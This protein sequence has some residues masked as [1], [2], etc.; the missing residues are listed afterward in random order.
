MGDRADTTQLLRLWH[1]GDRKAL[2]ALIGRELPWVRAQAR[3]RLGPLLKARAETE[4]Y[5]QEALLEVLRYAPRFFVADGDRFRALLLRI[6]ENVI[7]DEHDR[8]SA[9]RRDVSRERPLPPDSVLHLDPPA[10]SVNRPSQEA[11]RAEWEAWVRLGME[12][13]DPEVRHVLV[14]RHWDGLSFADMG[15]ALGIGE[16]AARM[17]LNR[18]TASLAGRI[19]ELRAG[20][21][22]GM[23]REEGDGRGDG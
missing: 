8:Y 14:L 19:Q 9:F 2:E 18:A 6:L 3:R 13:L 10:G 22:G 1:E 5:V 21:I 4:D 12:L 20:R 16:D 23:A 17:R 7:R 15:K 11:E